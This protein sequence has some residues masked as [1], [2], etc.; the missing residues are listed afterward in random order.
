MIIGNDVSRYQGNIDFQKMKDAGS[1]F[2]YMRLGVG[3]NIDVKYKENRDQ[4]KRVGLPWGH[5]WLPWATSR[6][7][8]LIDQYLFMVGGDWGDLPP[9]IDVETSGLGL[10]LFYE[11]VDRVKKE[12]G[13]NPVFY[14]R[15]SHFDQYKDAKGIKAWLGEHTHL[16]VAHYTYSP[17]KKP[18]MPRGAWKDYLI[19]Q[20]SADENSLGKKYGV[21]SKAIDMDFFNGSVEDF[22][23]FAGIGDIEDPTIPDPPDDGKR[24]VETLDD[25]RGRTKPIYVWGDSALIFK[26]GERLEL[27]DLPLVPDPEED[28]DWQPVIMY[29]SRKWIRDVS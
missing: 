29:V 8:A 11:W 14:T 21:S 16:W 24:Y 1:A 26:K 2:V 13:R 10:G 18:Y 5:Y 19:H 4:V 28:I 12:S 9:A 6:T 23:A 3:F 27:A 17:D 25:L 22:V 7:G 15:A 20:Y